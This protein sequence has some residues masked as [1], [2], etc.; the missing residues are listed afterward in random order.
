MGNAPERVDVVVVGAG[1]AGVTAARILVQAGKQVLVLEGHKRVGG[2]LV[3]G[4]TNAGLTIDLGGQ[5]IGPGQRRM[6]ALV[7]EL[8]LRTHPTRHQGKTA[9]ELNGTFGASRLGFPLTSLATLLGLSVAMGRVEKL[10]RRAR[11]RPA[12]TSEGSRTSDDVSLGAFLAKQVWPHGAR[13]V[14]RS[15]FE[16]VFC[17]NADE[18]SMDLALYAIGASGGFA[19]MQAVAGGAQ[20]RQISEGAGTLVERLASQLGERVRLQSIVRRIE[21]R[22]SEVVVHT[23]DSCVRALDV[24]LAIPPTLVARLE[25]D[26]PLD[27]RRWEVMKAS[28]MG[29]VVKYTLIYQDP[30]WRKS[31][32]S[33][34]VWSTSGPV[35]V[36]Y[37]TTPS[38]SAQGVVSALS[39]GRSA[40]ELTLLSPNQRKEAVLE[41]I[42][43]HLGAEARSPM[44]YFELV[45]AHEPLVEGGYSITLPPGA[46]SLG[47]AAFAQAE[48]P[49]HFAGTETANEYPGYM[50]GAVE[51]GERAARE[52][53]HLRNTTTQHTH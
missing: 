33:G 53:L 40:E 15:A 32:L 41:A 24:V 39:V 7:T 8:G 16:G 4:R 13:I 14:L 6:E 46:F 43:S 48:G 27:A 28:R 18:I 52:I 44:E 50:E 11:A 51:S 22:G 9:F 42:A 38:E 2:R 17:R 5:W 47:P 30:F 25:F 1:L 10:A 3:S 35:N 45:W 37:D 49:L 21:R 26:P 29:H 34:A 31:G 23:D 20:E 12:W 36:C 19:H